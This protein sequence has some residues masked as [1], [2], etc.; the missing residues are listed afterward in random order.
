MNNFHSQGILITAAG[1]PVYCFGVMWKDK[2]QFVQSGIG[3]YI[4]ENSTGS[5]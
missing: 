3:K 2:P 5:V 1:I 4:P